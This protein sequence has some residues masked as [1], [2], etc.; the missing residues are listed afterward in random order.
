MNFVF[1]VDLPLTTFEG[2][3]YTFC[4]VWYD[5]A[6][7]FRLLISATIYCVI[8]RPRRVFFLGFIMAFFL[9]SSGVTNLYPFGISKF[10]FLT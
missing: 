2:A 1:L 4:G 3:T 9:N 7:I 8:G 10:S 6:F 5:G